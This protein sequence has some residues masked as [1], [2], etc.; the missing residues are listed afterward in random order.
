MPVT[1]SKLTLR[2]V[3][4]NMIVGFEKMERGLSERYPDKVSPVKRHVDH[5]EDLGAKPGICAEGLNHL[6]S[7]V[8][9][10]FAYAARQY[11]DKYPDTKFEDFVAIR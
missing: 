2:Y 10:M 1:I 11:C 9:K 3:T 6:T 4:L 5:M 8:I 7:D